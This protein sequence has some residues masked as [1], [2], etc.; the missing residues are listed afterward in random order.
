MRTEKFEVLV[1]QC[2]GRCVDEAAV[3]NQVLLPVAGAL[4]AVEPSRVVR[5]NF[6]VPIREVRGVAAVS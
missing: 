3:R 4:F 2:R 6:G 1:V 5:Q